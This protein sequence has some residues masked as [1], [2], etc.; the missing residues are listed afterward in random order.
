MTE[1]P[2]EDTKIFTARCSVFSQKHSARTVPPQS[3]RE[4]MTGFFIDKFRLNFK[5]LLTNFIPLMFPEPHSSPLGSAA[6]KWSPLG[7][8]RSGAT[9]LVTHGAARVMS[10][11]M[12]H[13][14][15]CVSRVCCFRAVSLWWRQSLGGPVVVLVAVVVVVV[16]PVLFLYF[17]PPFIYSFTDFCIAMNVD[18]RP[19]PSQHTAATDGMR[20]LMAPGS[21]WRGPAAGLAALVLGDTGCGY[22]VERRWATGCPS[23]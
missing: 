17:Y 15:V 12:R 7:P 3:A 10:D 1:F 18:F 19:L 6:P 4:S 13:H 9:P 11:R 23:A 14:F 16:F 5:F 22:L 8:K 20:F 21:R 2:P